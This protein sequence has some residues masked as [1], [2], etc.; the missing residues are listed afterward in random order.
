MFKYSTIR[1][2][3]PHCANLCS[4][5]LQPCVCAQLVQSITTSPPVIKDW[6][7]IDRLVY[8]LRRISRG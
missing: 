5:Q 7:P 3:Y 1:S 2:E 6:E 8:E 4:I